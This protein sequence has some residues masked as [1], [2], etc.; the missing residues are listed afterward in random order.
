[1][2]SKI[3]KSDSQI[4]DAVSSLLA[5]WQFLPYQEYFLDKNSCAQAYCKQ[6][7]EIVDSEL[8][9][10]GGLQIYIDGPNLVGLR[11]I[12]G[13]SLAL[14]FDMG[15]LEPVFF[16]CSSFSQNAIDRGAAFLQEIV[17][18]SG[19]KHISAPVAAA[20]TSAQLILQKCGFKLADTIIGH[21]VDLTSM[22]DADMPDKVRLAVVDDAS[23]VAEICESNFS[24]RKLSVN[25]FLS[26]LLFD[27]LRVGQMYGRWASNAIL[28]N[29]CDAN[30]VFDD[31]EISGFYTFRLPSR[32]G[33]DSEIGLA[34]AV[35]SAVD[36]NA[37]KKGVFSS[38]QKAGCLW[39]KKE[40]AKFVEVKTVL[41]NYP[42]NRV[43]QKMG[44][45]VAMTYHTFHWTRQ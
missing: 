13:E 16:D 3:E 34:M 15:R 2:I 36:P 10:D 30:L 26:D 20:D 31:G 23:R 12:I 44:A 5:K 29:D 35:L 32:R 45:R 28:L 6:F 27:P 39:L 18:D 19:L 1:M 41:P 14:G 33:A 22:P 11:R 4:V 38:L 17:E 9:Q 40:G 25:R 24:D 21:H 7:K 8:P 42:V 43:S 37:Q